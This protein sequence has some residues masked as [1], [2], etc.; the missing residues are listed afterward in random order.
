VVSFEFTP[1]QEFILFAIN[2]VEHLAS[3]GKVK[4]NYS[5]GES[6]SLV[7]NEWVGPDEISNI[8]SNLPK[9]TPISGDIYARFIS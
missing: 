2:T 8:L 7:L 9:R 6:I 1:T 3:I 4:F 5:F